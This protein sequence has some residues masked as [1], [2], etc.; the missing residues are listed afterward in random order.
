MI[1]ADTRSLHL[2]DNI[3]E[4]MILSYAQRGYWKQGFQSYPNE[5]HY[6]VQVETLIGDPT[7]NSPWNA[8]VTEVKK[9]VCADDTTGADA[10]HCL[11]FAQ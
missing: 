9:K 5:E 3:S 7:S 8:N 11:V 1:I 2:P 10:S 4:G 6:S